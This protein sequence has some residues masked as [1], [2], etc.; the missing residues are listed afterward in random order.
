[1]R[2]PGVP[3]M[4][5]RFNRHIQSSSSLHRYHL[6]GQP[7]PEERDRDSPSDEDHRTRYFIIGMLV[8]CVS[9]FT[10]IR[11]LI[12]GVGGAPKNQL[13]TSLIDPG[14]LQHCWQ[15]SGPTSIKDLPLPFQTDD[16]LSS[17][18]SS[19]DSFKTT[20]SITQAWS[21]SLE[22]LRCYEYSRHKGPLNNNSTS[23]LIPP[24]HHLYL[25]P[26][27][28]LRLQPQP[29]PHGFDKILVPT[30][31]LPSQRLIA[32]KGDWKWMPVHVFEIGSLLCTAP[33][34]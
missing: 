30:T 3:S 12:Y 9:I 33:M 20:P 7:R 31:Q 2:R 18:P 14:D 6:R 16:V 13:Q 23:S 19:S 25:H 34:V 1:M 11:I 15:S 22:L 21:V 4:S 27:P 29:P 24:R 10:L 26:Q 17:K 32:V 5:E 28:Q 8:I